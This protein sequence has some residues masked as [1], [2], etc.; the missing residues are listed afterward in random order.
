MKK[1]HVIVLILLM[2]TLFTGCKTRESYYVRISRLEEQVDS[3]KNENRKL[4]K[5]VLAN[6]AEFL[7]F[8]KERIE[9]D[10]IDLYSKS[11]QKIGEGFFIVGLESSTCATGLKLSG[12][13]INSTSLKH[14]NIS[15]KIT[16]GKASDEFH[17]PVISAGN[18]TR[19][20]AD[21]PGALKDTKTAVVR[22]VSS[23]VKFCK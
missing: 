21:I 5:F 6:H 15:F 20:K 3:L 11:M 10:V 7:E 1:N 23:S 16:I 12:R 19:F 9:E 17:V 22:Y 4:H 13:I 2:L 14:E 18:S 8:K